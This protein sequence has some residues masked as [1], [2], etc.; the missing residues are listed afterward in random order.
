MKTTNSAFGKLDAVA[1]YC[2]SEK[3][4]LDHQDIDFLGYKENVNS[5]ELIRDH[6]RL[7]NWFERNNVHVKLLPFSNQQLS[8]MSC[9][10]MMFMRDSFLVLPEGAIIANMRKEVRRQEIK[11]VKSFLKKNQIETIGTVPPQF[12]FE[13]ADAVWISDTEMLVGVGKRTCAGG[14][15]YLKG[16]LENLGYTVYSTPIEISIP[17]QHLL[18]VLQIVDTNLAFGRTRFLS[19]GLVQ[20]F[21]E[22]SIQ[23][24]ELPENNEVMHKQAMN[25]VLLG[26]RRLLMPSNC[27]TTK[28]AFESHGMEVLEFHSDGNLFKAGG[29][30]ACLTNILSRKHND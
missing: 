29:G 1:L 10:N 8:D 11:H 30:I 14:F 23:L 13:S 19:K 3:M 22:K 4:S 9:F 17:T 12:S 21:E 26:N 2:P 7:L 25:I 16:I 6:N 20:F 18:G 5:S 15:N 28:A 24:I 27:P